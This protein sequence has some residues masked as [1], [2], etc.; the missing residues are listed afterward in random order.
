MLLAPYPATSYSPPSAG[1]RRLWVIAT[2]ALLLPRP[3]YSC[4]RLF[5]FLWFCRKNKEPT[6]GL[7]PL[8]C[9]LRVII[10]ALHGFARACKFPIS[11]GFSLPWLALRCTVLRSRWCQSG[12]ISPSYPLRLRTPSC[13]FYGLLREAPRSPSAVPTAAPRLTAGCICSQL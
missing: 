2:A 3:Q 12:V 10:Q 9:S 4:W 8:T 1:W 7:E 5:Y 13:W 11:K 6:S